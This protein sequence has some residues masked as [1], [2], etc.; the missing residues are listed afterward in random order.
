MS[1]EKR[2]FIQTLGSFKKTFW[3]A[4]AMEL[5]ERWAWYGIFTLLAIYLVGSTDEGGLGFSHTEKGQLMGFI[6]AI[7]YLLPL[8][9]GVI[10]D[11]IGYKLSLIIAYI[12]LIA[13][14]YLMG[15]VS[16]Y[17]SVFF[18]FLFV[19]LGAA[20]FKPVASAIVTKSTDES[21]STLGFG[22]FYMMVNIGG[23]IGP[24]M[25]SGLRS[26]YGWKLIFI[27]ASVVIFI[28]L[29]IVIFFFKE[30]YREITKETV[31]EAIIN[32]LKKIWEAIKDVRLTVL[33]IIM[34]GF[35]T[36]FNQLFNT[37]PNF[38]EDWVDSS[39]LSAAVTNFWPALGNLI[40]DGGQV[41]PEWFTN[42][43]ALMIVFLQIFVS[44]FVLKIRHVS[45]MV[46][47]FIIATI[48][49]GITFYTQNVWFTVI[50]TVIFAIGEMT[51]NPTFSSFI[52]IISPRGKEAL[53]QGTYFLPVAA[54]NFFTAFV[55]GNLY[56]AWSDKLSLLQN[57]MNVRGIEMPEVTTEFSKNNYYDLAAQKLEMSQLE[58]TQLLWNNYSPNKIW[59]VIVGIG[60]VTILALSIYDRM[61]IRPREAKA[62]GN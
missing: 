26:T 47:G 14:Y 48:G 42:I 30:P 15:T 45:A 17:W 51:T 22:I 53:Y 24:A 1:T 32:S 56:Q 55:S 59:Y 13:G 36:L 18:V 3:V 37:L 35:W 28:N 25:S 58:V 31:S 20:L 60:I 29:L 52:A 40:S 61:V 46:R 23:F 9:T 11:K 43:D 39:V 10:A 34:V 12:M 4:S 41:K 33:L 49:I 62:N 7:L 44:Y 19:A 27:Q 2:T 6:P 57:E 38:I 50:G 21:N 8:F 5:F 54:G 16:S